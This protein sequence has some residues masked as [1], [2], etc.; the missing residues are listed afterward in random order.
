MTR[1]TFRAESLGYRVNDLARLLAHALRDRIAPFGVVPGQFP[2][3]LALYEE[4]GLTQAELC[5]RVRVEQPTMANTL[6]R[7][8]RDG[9]VTRAPDPAD[10]RRS[11]VHLTVRARMIED[12]L[13][14]AASSVNVDA[15]RGV[16]QE[17]LSTFMAVLA[18]LVDNLEGRPAASPSVADGGSTP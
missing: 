15:T 2:Q 14:S 1:P 4:D 6:S 16:E 10:G 13:V 11:L 9:L 18:E 8:E 3:L 7:M 17:R 12:D 5:R